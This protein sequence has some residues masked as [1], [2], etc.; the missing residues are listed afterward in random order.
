L[1]RDHVI[2]A[3]EG[4]LLT[5]AGGKWTTYR[6]MAL[7]TVDQALKR[8]NLSAPKP[9]CQTEQLPIVGGKDF[10]EKGDLELSHK[11]ALAADVAAHLNRAYGDQA[12]K[13]AELAKKGFDARLVE[14]HPALEAEVLYAV[15]HEMAER[16]IDV[17]ARRLSL[18]LLDTESARLALPRVLEIMAA[19]LSWDQ[20]RCKAETL[21][22]EKRL[23]EAL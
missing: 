23:A 1:T 11:F 20:K 5:I 9:A 4:G 7:D 22:A 19:E 6:K 13:V 3:S 14:S 12:M 2:E 8:F 18:A 21:V 17:L 10:D 16:V 15:R